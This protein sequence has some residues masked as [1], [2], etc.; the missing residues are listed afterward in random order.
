DF[1]DNAPVFIQPPRNFTLRIPE[2]MTLGSEI[3]R[4]LASDTDIGFNGDVRYRLR[5]DPAGHHNSFAINATSGVIMLQRALDRE[6][7]KIYEIRV[8]AYDLGLPTSLQSDLDLKI[9]VRN[10]NDHE[11]QFTANDFHANFTE[12]RAPGKERVDLLPTVDR[13]DV[14]D[15]IGEIS[16][17]CY[18][19]V[20]GENRS[21]FELHPTLH[22]L[23]STHILDREEASEHELIV[24]ATEECFNVPEPVPKF[25]PEDDTLLRVRVHVLDVNDNPPLFSKSIFTGGIATDREF[26]AV[27]MS[28]HATDADDQSSLYYSISHDILHSNRSEG[29][30]DIHKPE[31]IINP[32]TGELL[33]NFDVQKNMKGFFSFKVRVRDEADDEEH[34]SDE[35]EVRVY[36]LRPDQRVR[37]VV[38]SR[39]SEIRERI[40][41]F[42]QVLQSVTG[43]LVNVDALLV[44][45]DEQGLLD[46]TKTDVLLHFVD[47]ESNSV[48]DVSR[49]LKVIDYKT[50]ELDD[51]FK[52]FNVLYTDGVEPTFEFQRSGF[53]SETQLW[54]IGLLA[55]VCVLLF[56]VICMCLR[57]KHKFRRRLRAATASIESSSTL[58]PES[59]T[60]GAKTNKESVPNTNLHASE[61]SNPI[62]LASLGYDNY[63]FEEEGT[64]STENSLDV[65]VLNS[66]KGDASVSEEDS[67]SASNNNSRT[68]FPQGSS[69]SSSSTFR[70]RNLSIAALFPSQMPPLDKLVNPLMNVGVTTY[71]EDDIPRTEL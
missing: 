57:Q 43:A 54:L 21:L 47:P 13:D 19:L 29:I 28:V 7:Q 17:V 46:R 52:D 70:N 45:K 61:G 26:G 62:W 20:G 51:I 5:P 36:L 30:Q 23:L 41:D 67:S 53:A 49:V 60:Q 40:E 56:L 63:T 32:E 64:K 9:F 15:E 16:D 50:E 42:A 1:N 71:D 12:G 6:R 37:F 39:P 68:L 34:H 27:F 44:H 14:E 24:K 66:P 48:F 8:V 11:P 69:S 2:N 58:P 3:I 65:N 38:R 33:V 4:V 10:I 31:F 59:S 55:L 25:D 18:F 35:A 22:E